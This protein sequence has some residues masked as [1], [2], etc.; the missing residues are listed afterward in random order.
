METSISS[1][2]TSYIFYS[3]RNEKLSCTL[4]NIAFSFLDNLTVSHFNN[5]ALWSIWDKQYGI[6]KRICSFDKPIFDVFAHWFH[7]IIHSAWRFLHLAIIR[8]VH[9]A[10]DI[11]CVGFGISPNFDDNCKLF[12]FFRA[13]TFLM[14]S[15]HKTTLCLK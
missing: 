8:I 11:Y 14:F 1:K 2:I 9:L 12:L 6:F 10:K 7:A 13:H 5:L 3:S 15:M 4:N